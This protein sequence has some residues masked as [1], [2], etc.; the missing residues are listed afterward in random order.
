MNRILMFL[1]LSALCA[2]LSAQ[3]I[4]DVDVSGKPDGG[5]VELY[6]GA[7][8]TGSVSHGE[9]SGTWVENHPNSEL[10]HFIIQFADNKRNGLF[11]EFDRQGNLLTKAEYKDGLRNGKCMK[12]KLSVMT[13]SVEYSNG[14][15]HGASVIC[16]DK[17]T[18]MEESAYKDG[19]RDGITIWYYYNG[20]EQ[21]GKIA[22]YN[23]KDGLF[24]GIQETYFE[25]GNLKSRKNFVKNIQV[26]KS[27]EFYDDGSLKSVAEYKEGVLKGQVSEYEKGT[28]FFK[29][30]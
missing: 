16:Y 28:S 11:I 9:K 8:V 19:N 15:R 22:M 14:K 18:I 24:D 12:F 25:N 21:G 4:D 13:E 2:E 7:S 1:L 26:G 5:Y 6:N 10:P 20:K 27:V 3:H 29:N 23:Y 17:G 30:Q